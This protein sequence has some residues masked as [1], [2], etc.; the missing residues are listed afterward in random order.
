MH[1]QL[2]ALLAVLWLQSADLPSLGAP[3]CPLLPAVRQCA[4]PP[5]A[6]VQAFRHPTSARTPAPG[7]WHAQRSDYLQ[8][9]HHHVSGGGT[10]LVLYGVCGHVAELLRMLK[11]L[12]G[13]NE[14]ASHGNLSMM[15]C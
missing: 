5:S 9:A 10:R 14:E 13:R 3:L 4:R 11:R 6:A 8:H 15:W 12:K 1:V 2:P 7:L